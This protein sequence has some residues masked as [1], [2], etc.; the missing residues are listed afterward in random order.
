MGEKEREEKV[1]GR[2][3]SNYSSMVPTLF[4]TGS[5]NLLM[6][7]KWSTFVPANSTSPL[8]SDEKTCRTS[9]SVRDDMC[10]SPGL[11]ACSILSQSETVLPKKW[12]RGMFLRP[13]IPPA[14]LPV[15]EMGE[16]GLE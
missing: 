16:R 5:T 12:Y 2:E 11:A 8:L 4:G 1:K 13:T 15:N 3:G 14:T 9:A 10:T 6:T 7:W